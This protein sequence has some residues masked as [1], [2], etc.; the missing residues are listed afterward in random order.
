M[1]SDGK[2]TQLINS[3]ILVNIGAVDTHRPKPKSGSSSSSHLTPT[4]ISINSRSTNAGASGEIVT[5]CSLA[6]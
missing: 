2:G 4:S 3:H 6:V 1:T 5:V